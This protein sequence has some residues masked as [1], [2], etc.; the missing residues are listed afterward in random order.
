M[1]HYVLEEF[2]LRTDGQPTPL[3][4]AG[5]FSGSSIWKI[6]DRHRGELCLKRWPSQI[7]DSSRIEWIHNVLIFAAANGCPELVQPIVARSG[8]TWVVRDDHFWELSRWASGNVADAASITAPQIE[9]AMIW[10]AK[11][12]QATA[13]YFFNFQPS[14][15]VI[16]VRDHLLNLP[17]AIATIDQHHVPARIL[18]TDSWLRFK[19]Q[20][21]AIAMDIARFLMSFSSRAYPVQP[22]IRDLRPDHLFFDEDNQVV[23][24]IDFSSMNVDTIACDLARLLG[25]FFGDKAAKYIGAMESYGRHRPI[26][27]F[28]REIIL[29]LNHASVILGITHWLQW[30]VVDKIQFESTNDAIK[31][32]NELMRR[33]EE[34]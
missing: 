29:P 28:E 2:D 16:G 10:L 23:A 11:F 31:R 20:A 24:V 7:N 34:Y 3:G 13:R 19:N 21:P 17:A 25:G 18:A 9:S 12:H 15:K 4:N 1:I 14:N 32:I 6:Q 8:K 30:L 27:S 5:G 22:V 33:F 26:H